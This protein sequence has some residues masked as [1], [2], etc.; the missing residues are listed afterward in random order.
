MY[1][2]D[3]RLQ[4][5]VGYLV[6]QVQQEMTKKFYMTQNYYYLNTH[7]HFDIAYNDVDAEAGKY[8]VRCMLGYHCEDYSSSVLTR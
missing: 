4:G 1:V 2:D 6:Q 3:V 7:L 8:R 5:Q